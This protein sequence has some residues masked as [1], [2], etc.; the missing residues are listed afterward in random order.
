MRVF[1]RY[2]QARS[3]CKRTVRGSGRQ[4]GEVF[5]RYFDVGDPFEELHIDVGESSK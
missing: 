2:A 4:I 1:I 5:N 3:R